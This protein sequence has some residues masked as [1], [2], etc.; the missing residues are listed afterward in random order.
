MPN[1]SAHAQSDYQVRLEWGEAGLARLAPALVVVIAAPAPG[2]GIC[3]SAALACAVVLYRNG[4]ATE[5]NPL[6][7]RAIQVSEYVALAA[8]IPLAFWLTGVYAVVR[9]MS[10]T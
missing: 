8:V 5:A 10:L 7:R 4:V 9:E 6:L 1:T 3:A 2:F